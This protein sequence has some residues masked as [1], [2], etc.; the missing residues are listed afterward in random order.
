MGQS[1]PFDPLPLR[2]EDIPYFMELQEPGVVREDQME[3]VAEVSILLYWPP[4]RQKME[5]W[6]EG[7]P[8]LLLFP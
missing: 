4:S 7:N 6:E 1:H 3:L 8:N 5:M 2:V